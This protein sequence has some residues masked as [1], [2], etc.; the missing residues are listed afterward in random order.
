MELVKPPGDSTANSDGIEV[1]QNAQRTQRGELE[2]TG[3]DD[4]CVIRC[5]APSRFELPVPVPNPVP[6]LRLGDGHEHVFL[7]DARLAGWVGWL[8]RRVAGCHTHPKPCAL[9][10]HQAS[11]VSFGGVAMI[12]ASTNGLQGPKG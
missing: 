4:L 6:Q 7:F 9:L 3:N 2:E 1:F 12:T 8:L 11:P 5:S 10:L